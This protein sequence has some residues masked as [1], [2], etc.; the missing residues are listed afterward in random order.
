MFQQ[1][2]SPRHKPLLPANADHSYSK[3]TLCAAYH[4]CTYT[5]DFLAGVEARSTVH[6]VDAGH[7]A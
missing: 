1:G 5:R 6:I 4:R 7:F 3:V 2:T